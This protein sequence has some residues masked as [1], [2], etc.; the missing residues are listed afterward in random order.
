[1]D[2]LQRFSHKERFPFTFQPAHT[3]TFPDAEVLVYNANLHALNVF[4]AEQ[5]K[6]GN[7]ITTPQRI[8]D[9][10]ATAARKYMALNTWHHF[11]VS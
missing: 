11:S 2:Y 7:R 8:H 1:M 6:K 4:I 10:M 9:E 5:N 3:I